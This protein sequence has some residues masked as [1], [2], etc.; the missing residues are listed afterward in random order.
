MGVYVYM[1]E[2]Q[3]KVTIDMEVC[4][5]K[6]SC[7]GSNSPRV[8]CKFVYD[9]RGTRVWR[10]CWQN[11]FVHSDSEILQVFISLADL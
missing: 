3:F 4:C 6:V 9:E 2:L 10:L 5:C 8:Y 1:C 11:N 7:A